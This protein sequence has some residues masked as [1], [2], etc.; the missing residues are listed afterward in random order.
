[1]PVIKDAI[2]IC[3]LKDY[4]GKSIMM[5]IR[6]EIIKDKTVHPGYSVEMDVDLTE[7]MD[8]EV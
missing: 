6:A 3:K 1:M 2:N 4:I 8:S 5:G 7:L